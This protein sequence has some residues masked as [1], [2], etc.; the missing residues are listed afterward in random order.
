MATSLARNVLTHTSRWHL[1]D[2]KGQ[3]IGRVANVV[4]H[5]LQGKHKPTYHPAVDG[6]DHVVVVNSSEATFT[7]RKWDRKTYRHAT[8]YPG[9]LKETVARHMHEAS[10]TECV[11]KAVYGMLP[12]NKLRWPRLQKLHIFAGAEHPYGA[13]VGAMVLPPI[14]QAGSILMK[15][16]VPAITARPHQ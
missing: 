9:G 7:G 15:G 16:S 14:K 12:K 13:N 1:I 5:L 2:A 10:P 3:P 11:R 6:G 4:C 8:M